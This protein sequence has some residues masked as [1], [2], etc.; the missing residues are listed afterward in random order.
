LSEIQPLHL[1]TLLGSIRKGSLNAAVVRTLPELAPAGMTFSA[2][3]S[4]GDYPIYDADLQ[5]EGFPAVVE[6]AAAAIRAADGVV[7]VSPE[8]NYSIPGGLKN[9]LDWISRLKGQ[10]FAGKP[11][12][13]QSVSAGLLGGA[14]MQYHLRQSLV[15]LDAH[16]LNKPEV[17]IGQ[18][19]AKID[20][21]TG[22]L[23]DEPTRQF[24]TTQL[25]AFADYIVR[26]R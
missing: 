6:E 12:A 19:T 24:I 5:A 13:I 8:Y 9:A 3:P 2:L 20:A 17:M 23:A 7:I 14:R 1:V 22:K 11:V 21:E 4:V 15:F 10:P 26:L 25:A 18:G 16:V